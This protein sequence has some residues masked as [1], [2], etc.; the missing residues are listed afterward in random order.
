MNDETIKLP[1]LAVDRLK[2]VFLVLSGLVEK[3][4]LVRLED[5]KASF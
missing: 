1:R 3:N 4:A 5:F 2:T